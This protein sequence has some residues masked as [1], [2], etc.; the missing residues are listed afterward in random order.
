VR[1]AAAT[2]ALFAVL[3]GGCLQG[4]R[5]RIADLYGDPVASTPALS[6]MALSGVSVQQETSWQSFGLPGTIY[7]DAPV[8]G[9]RL[10]YSN[11]PYYAPGYPFGGW[12]D[13]YRPWRRDWRPRRLLPGEQRFVYPKNEIRCDNALHGCYRW[14]GRQ[15]AYIYDQPQTGAFYGRRAARRGGNPP[16]QR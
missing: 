3:L 11:A 15:G 14:S 4:E 7:L 12:Y 1:G 6:G 8:F 10:A 13:P 9:G 16:R 2:L 5:P